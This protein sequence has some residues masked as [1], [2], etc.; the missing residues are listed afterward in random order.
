MTSEKRKAYMRAYKKAYNADPINKARAK[1][2]RADPINK[3]RAKDTGKAYDAD[4]INKARKKAYR[5]EPINK[6]RLN[7]YMRA[8]RADPINKRKIRARKAAST[9][10]KSGKIPTQNLCQY[11]GA[12]TKLE[13]HHPDTDYKKEND[14]RFQQIC[15]PCHLKEHEY[16]RRISNA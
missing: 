3:A 8:Y 14:L 2:Y 16:L 5:A 13:K 4:P 15:K 6:A 10:I 1:A 11:C 12:F 9:A 7:S